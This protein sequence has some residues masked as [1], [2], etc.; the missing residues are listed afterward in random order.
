MNKKAID[1]VCIK[2][3]NQKVS[4]EVQTIAFQNGFRWIGSGRE[5]FTPGPN[6]P[7]FFYLEDKTLTFRS[8]KRDYQDLEEVDELAYRMLKG[9]EDG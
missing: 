4:E 2:I 3:P 5:I 1:N 7:L 6:F 9:L 8:N